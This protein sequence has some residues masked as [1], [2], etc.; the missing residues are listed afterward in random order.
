MDLY[1]KTTRDELKDIFESLEFEIVENAGYTD[2]KILDPDGRFHAM[3]AK[4]ED[5]IYCDLHYDKNRHQWFIGVDYDRRP[6]EF[7]EKKLKEVLEGK[8]I[9]FEI[10]RVNWFTRRNK[11]ISGG[12]KL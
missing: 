11:A 10:K 6:Q 1:I 12:F 2:A 4:L 5:R 7:F 3:C 9:A 8:D